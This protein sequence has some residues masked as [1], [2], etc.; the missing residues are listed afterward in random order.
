MFIQG[1]DPEEHIITCKKEWKRLGYK[2]ERTWPHLFPSTLFE[3]PNKW[4]KM[5]ES[6]R[7]TFFWKSLKN[8]F[9]KNFSFSPV[10]KCLREVVE[11]IQQFI[12]PIECLVDATKKLTNLVH[13]VI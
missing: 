11:E 9:I 12:K 5:E 1:K 8:N 3:F 13:I 6:R 4:H 2:D 10:E 7:E